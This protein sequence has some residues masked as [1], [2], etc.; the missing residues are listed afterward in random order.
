MK[1]L[2]SVDTAKNKFRDIHFD[3]RGFHLEKKVLTF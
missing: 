3:G 2:I 1:G